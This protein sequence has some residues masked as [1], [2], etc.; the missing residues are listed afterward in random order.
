MREGRVCIRA[1]LDRFGSV[2]GNDIVQGADA[3][4]DYGYGKLWYESSIVE[5]APVAY[6]LR[7]YNLLSYRLI[8]LPHKE[9]AMLKMVG[10]SGQITLGK[11]FAGQCFEVTEQEDGAILMTPLRVAS[12]TDAW[13]YTPE[14]RERLEQATL[15]MQENPP[16]ET[17]LDEFLACVE[18]KRRAREE[19]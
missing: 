7:L 1:T 15:W 5:C 11:K 17:D 14:I 13:L 6:K 3:F 19:T 8:P 16:E 10:T 18:E 9:T 4:A 12:E 2:N